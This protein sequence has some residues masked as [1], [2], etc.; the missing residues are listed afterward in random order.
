MKKIFYPI[1]LV[2]ICWSCSNKNEVTAPNTP[3][4]E[5]QEVEI[6]VAARTQNI[7]NA[8]ARRINGTWSDSGTGS[9][10]FVW[11]WS[12]NEQIKIVYQG[13][14][15][16]FSQCEA[17]SGETGIATFKGVMPTG[18]T[19]GQEATVIAGDIEHEWPVSS[20][21][22]K[23]D[24]IGSNAMRF[25]GKLTSLAD[26]VELK[27]AW[28]AFRFPVYFHAKPSEGT[29]ID[30]T[31]VTQYTKSLA[32][33]AKCDGVGVNYT[34]SIEE[35]F[36]YTYQSSASAGSSYYPYY[37]C[38]VKP[39]EYTEL[40]VT[41]T[42]DFALCDV[43]WGKGASYKQYVLS[44]DTQSPVKTFNADQG[45]T[46]EADNIYT[47]GVLDCVFLYEIQQ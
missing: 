19:E 6:T 3:Y 39:G 35:E 34:Y 9:V 13:Q 40:S 14:E 15:A 24:G 45:G 16:I 11:E 31:S 47:P 28:S 21:V 29:L 26:Q 37:I 17:K 30:K 8:P 25:T 27:A 38:V 46:L 1:F 22:V 32:L 20:M 42:Y 18:W 23:T 5:G 12:G 41:I 10:Q 44:P 7:S 43:Y 4:Q 33:S 2:L 36:T